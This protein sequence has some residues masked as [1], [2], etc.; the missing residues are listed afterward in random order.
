MSKAK[1][2]GSPL[3]VIVGIVAVIVV[4]VYALAA[5]EIS[6]TA[7]GRSYG[8]DVRDYLYAA[9]NGRFGTLYDTAVHDM[10]R[11]ASYDAQVEEC[12]ALAFYYEQAVLEHAY[13]VTGDGE[14]AD[15][16][17][18]RMAE[19]EAQ[20]GSLAPKAEAVRTAVAG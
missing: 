20:L 18:Q 12:R 7:K 3:K 8:Y 13:R 14:A 5:L 15:A 10:A 4:L 16:F 2:A 9:E 1:V 19:Y 17:A 6:D 11:Q